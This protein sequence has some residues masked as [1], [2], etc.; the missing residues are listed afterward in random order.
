MRYTIRVGRAIDI[1]V[2]NLKGLVWRSSSDM[3]AEFRS[4]LSG[5]SRKVDWRSECEFLVDVDYDGGQA[6]L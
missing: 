6:S 4:K 3:L 1:P 2:T 5:E